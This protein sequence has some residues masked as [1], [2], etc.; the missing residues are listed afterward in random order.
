MSGESDLGPFSR[1]ARALL[2]NTQ[3]IQWI[4]EAFCWVSGSCRASSGS[5]TGCVCVSA[6]YISHARAFAHIYEWTALPRRSAYTCTFAHTH[7]ESQTFLISLNS[8][9][10]SKLL[11][12]FFCSYRGQEDEFEIASRRR[13][14]RQRGEW[15]RK[16]V[17]D[18]FKLV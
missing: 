18:W 7:T 6:F 1:W 3:L 15:Q 14:E 8:V 2:G 9:W 16:S 5:N 4:E 10:L 17:L 12:P 11:H 13:E